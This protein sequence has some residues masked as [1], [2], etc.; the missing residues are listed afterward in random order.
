MP[1]PTQYQ[2]QLPDCRERGRKRGIPV[3]SGAAHR[4]ERTQGKLEAAE[5]RQSGGDLDLGFD[6]GDE[7][8]V[9][10]YYIMTTR[11]A[12]MCVSVCMYECSTCTVA[13]PPV[14]THN[15]KI[16]TSLP[17]LT[18]VGNEKSSLPLPNYLL[19]IHEI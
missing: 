11:N 8:M 19:P 15:K 6:E 3:P 4:L 17:L 9:L 13:K 1:S 12:S 18:P 7:M 5:Y 16:F 2:H 10:I 14:I